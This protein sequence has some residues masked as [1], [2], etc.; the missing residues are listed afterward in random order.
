MPKNGVKIDANKVQKTLQSH[1][2]E[3]KKIQRNTKRG[4][5]KSRR[6]EVTNDK[7]GGDKRRGTH[8]HT[9]KT[10]MRQHAHHN[11]QDCQNWHA[12]KTGKTA[13]L[14]KLAKLPELSEP[15]AVVRFG[16][17]TVHP[18]SGVCD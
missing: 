9:H 17:L 15:T 6:Q 4:R 3:P 10:L 12:A 11:W 8:T 7:D 14:A 18:S 13:R 2:N 5:R 16:S 1:S